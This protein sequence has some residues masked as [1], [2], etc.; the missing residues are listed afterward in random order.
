MIAKHI[1]E[2][3]GYCDRWKNAASVYGGDEEGEHKSDARNE[4]WNIDP[5]ERIRLLMKSNQ[6]L[7]HSQEVLQGVSW[8]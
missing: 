8:S 5:G 4:H 3:I 6:V 2:V 1:I 7:V